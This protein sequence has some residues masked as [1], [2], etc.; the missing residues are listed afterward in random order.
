MELTPSQAVRKIFMKE[1]IMTIA[2]ASEKCGL[3]LD[4]LRYYEKIGLIPKISRTAGGI[5]NYTEQDCIWINF[6]KCMRHAGVSVN[7][8]VE[9]VRLFHQGDGTLNERKAILLRERDRIAAQAAELA[10]TLNY[11]NA[12]IERYESVIVPVE[13]LLTRKEDTL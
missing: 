5:R 10:E 11:L 4:T 7:A 6:A 9:Y 13:N 3:P 8:M 2:E 1:W 12:K